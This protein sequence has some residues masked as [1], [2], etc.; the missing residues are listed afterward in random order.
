VNRRRL[1]AASAVSAVVA[2][3]TAVLTHDARSWRDAVAR[4]DM[5]Y[6]EAP[7]RADWHAETWLPGDPLGHAVGEPE[8]VELRRAIRLFVIAIRTGRGFDNGESRARA[9]SVAQSALAAVATQSSG[10]AASQADDLLGVLEALGPGVT[11]DEDAAV[12]F[13]NAV[14]A[15]PANVDAKTNL[16]LA[17]RRLRAVSSRQGPGNGS[18]P[19]GTGR[20]G[21]GSGTPGRGY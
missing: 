5:T 13:R 4:G 10:S 17:L 6:A 20:R 16:E 21:A 14:L 18:G 9:R 12:S 19:R 8:S 15:D 1:A 7:A 11:A 2:V 3:A